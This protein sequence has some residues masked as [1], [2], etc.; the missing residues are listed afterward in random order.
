M[1]ARTVIA[2]ILTLAVIGTIATIYFTMSSTIEQQELTIRNLK[3]E[4]ADK[5][6][7]LQLEKAN[8]IKLTDTLEEQSIKIESFRV[9]Q[10]AKTKEFK[11]WKK[12]E[13]RYNTKQFN[14]KIDFEKLRQGDCQEAL[15]FMNIIKEMKYEDL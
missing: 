14:G 3:L 12:Q 10:D 7:A 8:V 13:D 6:V 1:G 2:T 11:N 4:V 5:T 15:N 9:Q